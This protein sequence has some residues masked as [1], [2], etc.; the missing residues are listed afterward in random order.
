MNLKYWVVT[1]TYEVNLERSSTT[2]VLPRCENQPARY[3]ETRTPSEQFIL[4]RG[5]CK[6]G[7]IPSNHSIRT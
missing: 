7:Q 1:V 2:D 5:Y 6:L 3:E 4:D